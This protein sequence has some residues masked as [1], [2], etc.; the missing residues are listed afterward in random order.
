VEPFDSGALRARCPETRRS[1]RP[2]WPA[3]G[4]NGSIYRPLAQPND[5]YIVREPGS[6]KEI[7]WDAAKPFEPENFERLK[8]RLTAYLQGR[9]L[10]VQDCYA[11]A[12]PDYQIPIRVVNTRAWH[13][14]FARNMFIREHDPV[15]LANHVPEF[16]VIDAPLFYAVP[17]QDGTRSEVFVVLNFK[18]R[19]VIIGGTDYAGEIKKSILAVMTYLLP[20]K[21][22]LPMHCSA[23]Y[24]ADEND[25]AI[26][27]GLSGTGKTTL[28]ADPERTLI[29]DDEHGWSDKGVFNFEGGC[30]AKVIR[31]SQEGEPEIYET[32][33][34]FGSRTSSSIRRPG[35]ST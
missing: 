10:F 4:S 20:P 35:G 11:G 32:T 13:N 9:D 22:V 14:L 30:Y 8:A 15:K 21:N 24:G 7:W 1:H 6:E 16:T 33:R 2:S 19:E 27:F 34:M 3:S 31:L 29:G 28:S 26:F 17:E 23:N 5:K 25:L 18:T 12:H